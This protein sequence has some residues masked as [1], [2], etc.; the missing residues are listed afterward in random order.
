MANRGSVDY[1][2]AFIALPLPC[3]MLARDMAVLAANHAFLRVLRIQAGAVIGRPLFE[4][5]HG[6][7]AAD[8]LAL[9]DALYTPLFHGRRESVLLRPGWPPPACAD[10]APWRAVIVPLPGADG[11]PDTLLF[12]LVPPGYMALHVQGE[13]IEG[14]RVADSLTRRD[15]FYPAPGEARADTD[16]AVA[17]PAEH[18]PDAAVLVVCDEAA[19]RAELVATLDDAGHR[20]LEA[21]DAA[22]AA[23]FLEGGVPFGLVVID[24]P[25]D[26]QAL[27]RHAFAAIPDV[28]VLQVAAAGAELRSRL[29]AVTL[30]RPYTPAQLLSHA[31]HMLRNRSQRLL[32]REAT[33][34]RP[35]AP[36]A[37]QPEAGA[38]RLRI[39]LVEDSADTREA[40]RDLL[41]VLGHEVREAG[42][43]EQAL[44]ALAEQQGFDILCT[45]VSLPG[46]SGVTLAAQVRRRL[47]GIGIVFASGFDGADI[48]AEA[49]GAVVLPKPY[50][51]ES[52]EAAMRAAR[53]H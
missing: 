8:L 46:M 4:S 32:F 15:T 1:Q 11:E 10:G 13:A 45:D 44:Q 53:G 12:C 51:P 7:D 49:L 19:T 24:L 22:T 23:R 2:A 38:A 28:E 41:E 35:L 43:G 36:L 6:L 20:V 48:D 39:L 17:R 18:M 30:G 26:A 16:A 25:D 40:A 31:R 50:T 47:P 37:A 3:A 52:L 34:G 33:G 42:S 14:R 21:G 29:G 9:R 27:V 5:L